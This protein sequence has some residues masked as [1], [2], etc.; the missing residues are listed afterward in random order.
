MLDR[1]ILWQVENVANPTNCPNTGRP[2]HLTLDLRSE[3][4]DVHFQVIPGARSI[5]AP[6]I[7]QQRAPGNYPTGIVH[8]LP[9]NHELL[10]REVNRF[11]SDQEPVPV[12]LQLH[13]TD[14]QDPQ[15]TESVGIDRQV[16]AWL[17]RVRLRP[18]LDR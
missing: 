6:S 15:P 17:R 14:S 11:S 5:R 13:V 7:F 12:E 2:V 9:Q 4:A 16:T 8:Q 18:R 1:V 10:V 3:P